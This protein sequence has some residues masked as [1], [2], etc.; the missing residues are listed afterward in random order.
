MK[1][2]CLVL[3]SLLTFHSQAQSNIELLGQIDYQALHNANLND[4]WGYVDE[5]GNEYAIV[6]TSK[7]TSIVD[8][9]DP[10]SP[11]EVFWV[12]GSTSIWRDPC[13][14]GDYAY[15]TTEAED[16]LTIIDLTPLPGSAVLPTTLYTGPAGGEW[17]SA[18]TC[19]VDENGV[20][21]IFGANRGQGGVI[22]LDVETNPM[23]PIELGIF[24]DWY[25]HD[26]FVRNDTMFLAH[27]NDGFFS[28]VDAADKANP[29]L[30]G[31]KH[32]P[33]N[34]THNIWPSNDGNNVFT[35]DEVSGA[36]ITSYSIQNPAAIEEVDRTQHSPGTGVIPHNTHVKGD[37]LITSYY[38][39]GITIHDITN[40]E[41]IILVGNYDTYPAQTSGFDGC[42]GVY[43]FLP[44]GTIIAADIT[45]GLYLLKPT[46]KKASYL[47]GDVVD[48]LTNL[49]LSQVSV[50]IIG[51]SEADFTNTLG[52]Y[53]SGI[54][55][56]NVYTVE[57]TKV[58]YYPQTIQLN[59]FQSVVQEQDI[60]LVP[61][62]PFAL[63][64]NVVEAGSGNPISDVQLAFKTDLIEHV[65]L[66]N[67]IGEE[68]LT[69]FYQQDY[70]VIAG[71]WGYK[72]TCFEQLVDQNTN[73]LTIEMEPGYMD[74]F[75]FDFGWSVAGTATSGTWERGVP[76][77]TNS[78]SAPAQDAEFDCSDK[79]FVTGNAN[80]LNPDNDDIDNGDTRLTSPLMDLTAYTDP[81]LNF[82]QW[83]YCYF[84]A[85]PDDT[86]E[87]VVS[88]GLTSAIVSKTGSTMSDFA[89]WE[90]V[91][92]R[93]Q[94]Y[95]SITNSM[96][97]KFNVSDLDPLINI[98]EAGIDYF[99]ISNENTL[100]SDVLVG[101]KTLIYPNPF[102]DQLL[103]SGLEIGSDI[104]VYNMNGQLLL[105]KN[106]ENEE[107]ILSTESLKSGIYFVKVKNEVFKVI[108]D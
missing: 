67:G 16:G 1:Y 8:V 76:N 24:D 45:E 92:I 27:I 59:L 32:T 33:N 44:S 7:G 64:V 63:T 90:P 72:T 34:F 65:G 73:L 23:A 50:Q 85:T 86:L 97:V 30:I 87:V 82:T 41:S 54:L 74:E 4:V 40:P 89:F 88:N 83:F 31:T 66:T 35:T 14:F 43:P 96:T 47:I 29:I 69:L 81:H 77:T 61:I 58:G 28:M 84:G 15:V 48:A 36:F 95:I 100:E 49:P 60:Q 51:N 75:T 19:F 57:Y 55:G 12:A 106:V 101:N 62:P 22:M 108:K 2:C 21:Y 13:V 98:T 46:Y 91:S 80:S 93:L 104:E 10:T 5:V 38:S 107:C 11:T 71:K 26:G 103:V 17:Q 68:N 70:M 3:I 42:W 52:H 18:H 39:D 56:E 102:N 99:F 78:G 9:S 53:S 79:A 94:D 105:S 37:F 25:A 20:A 6:G